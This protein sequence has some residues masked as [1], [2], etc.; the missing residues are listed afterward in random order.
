MSVVNVDCVAE[1]Y[2]MLRA[3]LF[4]FFVGK[5]RTDMATP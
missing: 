4:L 3:K 2:V 1:V 5:E